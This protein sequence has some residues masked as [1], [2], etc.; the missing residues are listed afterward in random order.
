MPLITDPYDYQA[1]GIQNVYSAWQQGFRNPLLVAPTGAGKTI[2]KSFAAKY[3]HQQNPGKL[4]VIF[5]HRDVLLEQISLAAAN[6][7]LPHRMICSKT[8]E[9]QIGEVHMENLGQSFLS[10]RAHTIIASVPTWIRRDISSVAPHVGFWAMDEAHHTLAG[11][12]WG[13]AV[14]PLSHAF[15]LGVTATPLR[16]DGKGLGRHHDGVFDTIVETP[17]M[18]DLIQRGRLA[19][20]K[21]FT[22]PDRIDTT[23][24]NVTSSGDYNQKKLAKATDRKQI[25]GDAIEHYKRLANGKQ[26][27]I[28]A[29]SVKHAEHVAAEFQAHGI[30]AVALSSKD[31][32]LKRQHAISDFRRGRITLLVNYDLFG[33]GF[34]V[35]AVEVVIMLRKTLSYGLFMQMFGRA[36][37]VIDGK[38]YGI[39]IDHVGNVEEHV[40]SQGRRHLHETPMWTL[41][42]ATKRPRNNDDS[43]IKTRTCP[44]CFC[45][46]VP[47]SSS[48]KSFVCPDCGHAETS[49]QVNAAA[50]EI[51]VKQG[52]L[53]EYDSGFLTE[54][55]AERDKVDTPV[56]KFKRRLQNAPPVVR[57]SAVRNHVARQN[58]Q[59]E[60]RKWIAQWCQLTGKQRGLDVPTTQGEFHRVFGVNVF[61]AQTL[62]STDAEELTGKIREN[63]F[64]KLFD[65][66]SIV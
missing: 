66:C 41:D 2:I 31:S 63:L 62:S 44:K 32:V 16:A 65:T 24:I 54:I 27:I 33:E 4:S 13:Q 34:D 47:A 9:R 10:D 39:L 26:G 56:E 3:F 45:F 51:Q 29:A 21:V 59:A 25:T 15:G 64:D 35:P 12:M 57:N 28:F 18:E 8:T 53:V 50:Q 23:G 42:R 22:P 1:Q 5:A 43:G 11:N 60:L 17:D 61:K 58:A 6:I 36:L 40:T 7:G 52:T 19:P 30:N 55:L 20:Y 48:P 37:R 49:T 46:Y 38:Q 14:S